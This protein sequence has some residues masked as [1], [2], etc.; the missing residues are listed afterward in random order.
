MA[1][2][3]KGNGNYKGVMLCNRPNVDSNIVKYKPFV[4]R[5]DKKENL[6]INPIKKIEINRPKKCLF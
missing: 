5:V 4:S 2:E 1:S 6:G 3:N